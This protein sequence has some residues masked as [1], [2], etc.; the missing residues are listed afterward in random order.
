MFIVS[1]GTRPPRTGARRISRSRT[2]AA[3]LLPGQPDHDLA[4]VDLRLSPRPVRLRHEH[5]D[6]AAASFRPDNPHGHDQIHLVKR[7][8]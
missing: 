1:A 7:L 6:R 3:D 4:E 2:K 8:S 5:L